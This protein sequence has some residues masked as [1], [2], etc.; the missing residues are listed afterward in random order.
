MN[1]LIASLFIVLLIGA[2]VFSLERI[3]FCDASY[4]LFRIVN[5]DT[6]QIQEHRYG[7]FIT[8]G[9][10]LIAAKL[11][12]P[13]STIVVLYSI[14][15]NLLYLAV[16][17]LLLYRFK[18]QTLALLMSFY[19]VLFVSDT[20]F[21][22]NNEVHQ[23]IAWMFLF[24]AATLAMGRKKMSMWLVTPI[25]VILAI[26]SVFTHPL[27]LF[28]TLF[29]WVFFLLKKDWPFN[30]TWTIIFSVILVLLCLN[31]LIIST[32][33]SSHYD[34]EKLREATHLS[35][36]KIFGAFVSPHAKEI[37]KRT[38]WNYWIAAILFVVGLYT[39]YREKKYAHILV[40]L[41]FAGAYFV[42]MCITFADFIPFYSESEWMP[43]TIIITT[44]FAYYTLPKLKPRI[45]VMLVASIFLIRLGYIGYSSQKFVERKEWIMAKLQTMRD[46]NIRKAIIYENDQNN[47]VLIMN[48]GVPTE[49]IIASALKKDEPQ[50]TFVVGSPENI[51][52]RM[53]T[54][55]GQMISC[56]EVVTNSMLNR[57]YFRFDSTTTYQVIQ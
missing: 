24:F 57:W 10:P 51:A 56:F 39:A 6:L 4:I 32:G 46:Q 12:L 14:S 33:A 47:K 15:F 20:Y 49:S 52:V 43:A 35:F 13:L 44:L 11:H 42:A 18:E 19:Y 3:L 21:W 54:E 30:K 29:L 36:K 7:S 41:A 26:L 1:R 22:T 5:F 17:L 28:P 37:F 48:W 31:K 16:A 23:G 40:T 38:L 45:A 34:S 9:F 2:F 55:P 25:F 53:V 8:Q 27:V 50:L